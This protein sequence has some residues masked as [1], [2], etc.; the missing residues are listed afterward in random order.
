MGCSGPNNVGESNRKNLNVNLNGKYA[1]GV[2]LGGT[3]VK[4]GY[5]TKDGKNIEKWEIIVEKTFFQT[6]PMQ[7]KIK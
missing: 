4:L 1:F 7:L 5:F 6:L 3:T 2:D